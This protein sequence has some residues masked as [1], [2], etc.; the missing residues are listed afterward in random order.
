MEYA[1]EKRIVHR[2]LKPE[3]IFVDRS[4][5]LKL[6]DFGV[7]QVLNKGSGGGIGTLYYS[8]PECFLKEEVGFMGSKVD[9][10]ALGCVSWQTMIGVVPF[11]SDNEKENKHEHVMPR[12]LQGLVH[13]LPDVFSRPL[14][15]WTMR[16]VDPDPAS[17][18]SA[19][20]LA[21]ID[22]IQ[23]VLLDISK[24]A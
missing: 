5:R 7:S 21:N 16:M 20:D 2:D 13:S 11:R 8:A 24:N 19:E 10:Y 23:K 12:V 18:P 17:R 6:G 15:A 4:G 14:R 3:N 1:H 9:V 22:F